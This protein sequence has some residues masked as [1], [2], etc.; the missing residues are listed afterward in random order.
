MA[1]IRHIAYRAED[2]E[3]MVEFFTNG[4]GLELVGR[5]GNGVVDLSDGTVNITLLPLGRA[6]GDGK[7]P[8]PGIEHIGFTATDED[9]AKE[10][11][12]AAGAKELTNL[13][14]DLVHYEHK[15]TGPEGI[16]VD[17]GHWAG[18]APVEETAE[19]VSGRS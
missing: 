7:E 6:R 2:V 11:I 4:L 19:A 1:K 5:R 16:I 13:Q 9:A 8:T 14:L 18:T 15:Y 10:R 3:G 17:L 12:Q